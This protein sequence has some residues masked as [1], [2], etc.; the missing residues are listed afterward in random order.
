MVRPPRL[1]RAAGHVQPLGRLALGEP[2]GAQM[3]LLC[4]QVGAFAARPTLVAIK[5]ARL[6]LLEDCC[7]SSLLYRSPYQVSNGGLRRA[8]EL[9]DCNP[10]L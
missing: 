10:S 7:H 5:I 6:L 3:A 4:T 9:L 2:L 8:R 1:Q